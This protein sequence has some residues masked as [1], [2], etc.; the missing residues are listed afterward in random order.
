[1]LNKAAPFRLKFILI[2]PF[3]LLLFV[4]A[5]TQENPTA[6]QVQDL[7]DKAWNFALSSNDSALAL[8][9]NA[10]E[11]SQENQYPLGEVLA[12]ESMGL[13]HEMVT[14]DIK[15]ASEQYFQA[16]ELCETHQLDYIS[17]VYHSL[18]VMFHTTDNYENAKRYY[19]QALEASKEKGDS[20]LIKKCL[21]NLGSIHSSLKDFEK[22]EQFMEQSL[23]I[24]YQ[25]EMDYTTYANLG[26]LYVK[27]ER[28][29]E[30]IE[31]LLKATEENPDNPDSEVNLYFLLNAKTKAQDSTDMKKALKRAKKAVI[32]GNQGIR[33]QSLLLRHI[34][35]YLAFTGNY[36]D[37][38]YYRDKYVE[39]YEE[40]K[41][42]Q[43][44]QIVLDM[45]TKYET[46]KK[47]S[48]L[49][50]LQLEGEKKEQ[51]MR[52]Y[53]FLA[54]A[55]LLIAGLVGF[56]LYK[57]NEKNRLLTLQKAELEK[58]VD[59]IH[60]LLNEIHHR[61]K[62]NLQVITSMLNIQQRSI[63][64]PYA[65]D[66]IQECKNRIKSMVLI[67]QSFYQ[68]KNLNE[69]NTREYVQNL[70]NQLFESYKTDKQQV[71][72][73]TKVQ[74][75]YMNIDTLIPLGLIINELVSNTLKHAFNEREEGKL[76]ISLEK[77]EDKFQLE[78]SDNGSGL[79]DISILEKSNSFGF[80]M[81]KA[82]VKK[83]HGQL[84]LLNTE[85]TTF[86]IQFAA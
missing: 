65:V 37:A 14:G 15:I 53:S 19:N 33:D 25:Q 54:I 43:R 48:Q 49:K 82:F 18:G 81:I 24:P 50:L 74:D 67:H 7:V 17:S 59:E 70:V 28:F 6:S 31:I 83:I 12:R 3:Y 66:A 77:I 80:K 60:L 29:E 44:D 57:N 79:E 84:N 16:I 47:D 52:L 34:A 5:F 22:A 23:E 11:L 30:A 39:V 38:L 42:K 45:E 10:L 76:S 13:Y 21:I 9:H 64:D 62:N 63:S 61:V 56:F 58:N 75:I 72:L 85:G 73:E 2:T 4:P 1:M 68:D 20:I 51:Q 35:D 71:E 86:Q 27:Q 46:E 26:H 78:I 69:I 41:E 8:A 32:S 40:I 55:G 36:E